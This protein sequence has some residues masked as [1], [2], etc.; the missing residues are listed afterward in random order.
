MCSTTTAGRTSGGGLLLLLCRCRLAGRAAELAVDEGQSGLAVLGTVALVGG[1]VV[2]V[3]AVRVGG[4]TVGLDFAGVR[5]LEAGR[6]SG[7]ASGLAGA[8]VVGE[9][10]FVARVT[11][12]DGGLDIVAGDVGRNGGDAAPRVCAAA[13]SVIHDLTS[14]RVPNEDELGVGAI[15]GEGRDG[16]N[17]GL[18]TLLG[19][20]SVRNTAARG[21]TTAGRVD[22]GLRSSSRVGVEDQV[23]DGDGRTVT[24]ANGCLTSTED[25]NGGALGQGTSDERESDGGDLHDFGALG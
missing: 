20:R 4:V 25:V 21:L 13:Q 14:L 24:R 2:T 7:E 23:D 10:R 15:L 6:A 8:D 3:A 19:R 12:E 22:D 11:H 17:D 5:A 18:G 16:A 1:G 9:T